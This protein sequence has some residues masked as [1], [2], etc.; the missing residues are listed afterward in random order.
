M[1]LFWSLQ[2]Y[3]LI[4]FYKQ[5]N[6][7]TNLHVYDIYVNILFQH[8]YNTLLGGP[9]YYLSGLAVRKG[10]KSLLLVLFL[11]PFLAIL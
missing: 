8:K 3:F 4:K 5:T 9:L 7:P 11:L 2:Y 1:I 6:K 10:R